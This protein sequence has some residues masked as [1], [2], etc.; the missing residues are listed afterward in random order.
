MDDEYQF[1]DESIST[2]E[3]VEACRMWVSN[4]MFVNPEVALAYSEKAQ[5]CIAKGEFEP[6]EKILRDAHQRCMCAMN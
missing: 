3:M 5:E 6:V 4:L 2:N 1:G